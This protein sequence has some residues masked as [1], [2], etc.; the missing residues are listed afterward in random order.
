MYVNKTESSYFIIVQCKSVYIIYIFRLLTTKQ[1]PGDPRAL[2]F[3]LI[4]RIGIGLRC[5]YT[6][7]L[8][9]KALW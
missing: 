4:I 6:P 3:L 2:L 9:V 5:G 7:C 8:P 1:K